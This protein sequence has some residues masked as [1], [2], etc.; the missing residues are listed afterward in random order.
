MLSQL[1]TIGLKVRTVQR[2]VFILQTIWTM[3]Q[4]NQDQDHIFWS[5]KILFFWPL[6]WSEAPRTSVIMVW[7]K[8]SSKV[9]MKQ[10]RCESPLSWDARGDLLQ[11]ICLSSLPSYP[12]PSPWP[13]L[14]KLLTFLSVLWFHIEPSRLPLWPLSR[15]ECIWLQP[16]TC[17]RSKEWGGSPASCWLTRWHAAD[18]VL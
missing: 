15:A 11:M 7:I 2:S 8:L 4:F 12:R 14:A 9:H 3:V 10:G 16:E 13:T 5:D 1:P 6:Q 17:L 18:A